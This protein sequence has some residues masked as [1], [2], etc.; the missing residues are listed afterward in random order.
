MSIFFSIKIDIP[1]WVRGDQVV[2]S[3]RL[4]TL[5]IPWV[6]P[7]RYMY[8]WNYFQPSVSECLLPRYMWSCFYYF[9]N[10]TLSPFCNSICYK[11]GRINEEGF[12]SRS[13]CQVKDWI[14]FIVSSTYCYTYIRSRPYCCRGFVF[15]L[16]NLSISEGPYIKP[17]FYSFIS[18]LISS[19]STYIS[20]GYI[21]PE[22]YFCD[23]VK[24]SIL[25]PN[26]VRRHK[27]VEVIK[28]L[29]KLKG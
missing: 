22:R 12:G 4:R 21:W 3:S 1:A 16:G 20:H 29:L 24:I 7:I 13:S 2:S 8:S 14:S 26:I 5:C 25:K 18:I 17:S 10:F 28:S 27:V 15:L 19:C 9:S 23:S 11:I 6:L